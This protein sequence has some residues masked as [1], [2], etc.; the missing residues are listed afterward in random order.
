MIQSFA[1]VATQVA[2]AYNLSTTV[3]INM[4]VMSFALLS[5][6]ADFLAVYLFKN[7]RVDCVLRGAQLISFSGAMFRFLIISTKEFWPVVIGTVFAASVSSIF[8]NSMIIVTN[9]W[10]S[11]TERATA[12]SILSVGSAVGCFVAVAI[13]GV[14]FSGIDPETE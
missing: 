5:P 7:Y 9:I 14:T 11:D 13:N 10:F 8:L 3:G 6:P 12:M 1:A 4:C 2:R